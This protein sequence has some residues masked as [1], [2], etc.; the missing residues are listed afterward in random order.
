MRN[1]VHEKL[2][3][4]VLTYYPKNRILGFTGEDRCIDNRKWNGPYF[5]EK[6]KNNMTMF[7]REL[8]PCTVGNYHGMCQKSSSSWEPKVS[9][10]RVDVPQSKNCDPLMC[11]SPTTCPQNDWLFR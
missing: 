1:N 8:G 2:I 6:F 4:L 7:V 3:N 5:Y 10:A 11:A 9:T